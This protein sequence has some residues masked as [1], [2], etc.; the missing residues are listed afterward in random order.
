[1]PAEVST[2]TRRFA[3]T[4]AGNCSPS[5]FMTSKSC[6]PLIVI[7]LGFLLPVSGVAQSDGGEPSLGDLARSLRK[8]KSA[9]EHAVIDND[10]LVQVMDG[11]KSH[12]PGRLSFLYSLLEGKHFQVSAPDVTCSLSFSRNT[13]SLLS[14]Q[15][16]Q[17]DLPAS[18]VSKLEGPAA[19][20]DGSLAVSI[21]N[22]TDWHVSEVAIALTIVKK[23]AGPD[24]ALYFGPARLSP[25]STGD[26]TQ[27]L[28]EH[29]QRRSD[30]TVLYKMR[31]AAA[32]SATTVFRTPLDL[33]IGPGQEWHWAIVQAKGYPP[34]RSAEAATQAANQVLTQAAPVSG[35]QQA[36][37]AAASTPTHSAVSPVR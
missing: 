31:A 28:D 17:L 25:V 37:P 10:N 2:L 23:A 35:I 30:V 6:L 12:H 24:M 13:K 16:V 14:S 15:Y 7:L 32:P 3:A 19:I 4:I 29:S 22:G 20:E 34:Q 21:F 8:G 33:E 18:E 26:E 5:K 27:E 9:P 1:M 11:A 36:L